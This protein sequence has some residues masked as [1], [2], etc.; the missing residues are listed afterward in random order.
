M[1]LHSQNPGRHTL[2]RRRMRGAVYLAIHGLKIKCPFGP[3]A[4]LR[5]EAHESM[6]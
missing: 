4:F 6:V 2:S 1:I 5:T 3:H